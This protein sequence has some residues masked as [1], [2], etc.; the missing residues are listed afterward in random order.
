MSEKCLS[1]NQQV[2]ARLHTLQAINKA[3][4][5]SSVASG[6]PDVMG[7]L[8]EAIDEKSARLSELEAAGLAG[9]EEHRRIRQQLN[10]W[11]EVQRLNR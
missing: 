11:S 7:T 5:S 2:L 8:K 10:R 6:L 4:S 9:G 1:H 3:R